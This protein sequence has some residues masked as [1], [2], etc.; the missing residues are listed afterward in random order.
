M[1]LNSIIEACY[2]VYKE[3]DELSKTLKTNDETLKWNKDT[4]H[5]YRT[6]LEPYVFNYLNLMYGQKLDEFW[7]THQ[8]PKKNKYAFVIV[9]RRIHPN[10][11]FVLRNIAWAAPNFSLYIF[12]SDINHDFIKTILGDKADNVNIIN[13]YKGNPDRDTAFKEYNI[14]FKMPSFYEKIDAEYLITVQMDCY[15]LQKIPDWIFCGTYYGAPWG[16]DQTKGGNGGLSIRNVKDMIE[17]CQKE[18]S[19]IL[20]NEGEDSHFSQMLE[21]YNYYL[22]PLEFRKKVIQ[23]SFPVDSIPIGTHQFWTYL[24]NYKLNNK[25]EF[26][27]SIEKLLTLIG[28]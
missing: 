20:N 17:I 15:F 5:Y 11:W 10:W 8:F 24:H 22:P 16:W 14:T 13:W 18:K 28:L 9:E 3:R 2:S 23:E 7:K 26:T 4:L 21:K 1:D 19:T 27:S 12:C 6:Q 25:T